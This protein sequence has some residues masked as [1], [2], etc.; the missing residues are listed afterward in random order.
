MKRIS[1]LILALA[2]TFALAS[3]GSKEQGST[4]DYYH[5]TFSMHTAA[6]TPIGRQFQ[7]MFDD[8]E[9]KTDGHVKISLFGSGT[10]ASSTD[11]ADMVSDGAC[12]IGWLFTSFYYGQY[13]LTDVI[14]VPG[15]GAQSCVQGTKVLW[16]LW[17]QYPEMRD[18]WSNYKVLVMFPNPVNYVYTNTEIDSLDDLNGLSIRS[19]SGGIA[20]VLGDLGCNVI[21]MSPNDIYDGISKNNIQ[22][23]ALEPTGVADYSLGEVT[24]SVL[25]VEMFQAPFVA[26]MNKDTWNSLPPEYQAVFEEWSGLDASLKFA[27]MWDAT[28]EGNMQDL[29][30]SGC[31][32]AEIPEEDRERFQ[33]VAGAYASSWAEQY[34][35]DSFDAYEY[36]E[37]CQAA[38]DRYAE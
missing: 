2:L 37:S 25:D 14:S 19:P 31:V 35:T 9:A 27:E 1:A 29:L 12:D 16:D 6:D 34:S 33:Q 7:A 22:G 24:K 28:A 4:E 36:Y 21:S 10:L 13:P 17:E 38:Y 30:D 11:V 3:C 32:M 5:L 18:E 26:I 8:I 20:E 23:Y 15:Q